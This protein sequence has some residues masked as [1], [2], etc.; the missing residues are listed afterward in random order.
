MQAFG[1]HHPVSM[2]LFQILIHLDIQQMH[3]GQGD[4]EA[5]FW[6][7]HRAFQAANA[8]PCYDMVAWAQ[9]YYIHQFTHPQEQHPPVVVELSYQIL[10]WTQQWP[11]VQNQAQAIQPAQHQAQVMQLA[12]PPFNQ[13]GHPV[14]QQGQ[15]IQ[16]VQPALNQPG[17]VVQ[18]EGQ[19]MQPAQPAF[20][21]QGHPVQQ[22]MQPIQ[23]GLYQQGYVV[24]QQELLIQPA[25]H[26]LHQQ[27]PVEAQ[28]E[29]LAIQLAQ[30]AQHQ[31]DAAADH[32]GAANLGGPADHDGAV[33]HG[34]V[35]D[36]APYAAADHAAQ[37]GVDDG[38]AFADAAG[39]GASFGAA[40]YDAAGHNATSSASQGAGQDAGDDA[41]GGVPLSSSMDAMDEDNELESLH[42]SDL[43]I[44]PD[45]VM[46]SLDSSQRAELWSQATSTDGEDTRIA[47]RLWVMGFIS[48]LLKFATEGMRNAAGVDQQL[49]PT[50]AHNHAHSQPGSYAHS[51]GHDF[52]SVRCGDPDVLHAFQ[53]FQEP[54]QPRIQ[55]PGASPGMQAS[56][57]SQQGMPNAL[58]LSSPSGDRSSP[59][60][61]ES[62][63][64]LQIPPEQDLGQALISFDDVSMGDWGMS[65]EVQPVARPAMSEAD[66]RRALAN[67]TGRINTQPSISPEQAQLIMQVGQ[68]L[69]LLANNYCKGTETFFRLNLAS[70]ANAA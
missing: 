20:N 1:L 2:Q 12:Q 63:Y 26:M 49:F 3:P 36:A 50:P 10:Q 62:V 47:L 58:H 45:M 8:D 51:D 27:G 19:V 29:G 24:Q 68:L 37:A 46:E 28:H 65:N 31:P 44:D 55:S 67:V 4:A 34:M 59:S 17:F 32:D 52:A 53:S 40:D 21:Q 33:H 38:A 16:P 60:T 39:S 57:S 25:Q 35:D 69:H 14:L 41:A 9:S 6:R 15:A 30:P 70:Y 5:V 18:Q 66:L 54:M 42:S 13:Q 48:K 43:E 64:D 7:M 23:P 61:Q 22:V 11:D 56:T